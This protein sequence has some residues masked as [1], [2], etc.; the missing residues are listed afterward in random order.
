MEANQIGPLARGQRR[1]DRL[2]RGLATGEHPAG[3]PPALGGELK[4]DRAAVRA[5]AALDQ[6]G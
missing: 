2:D 4:G 5:D 6:P 3:R 1:E